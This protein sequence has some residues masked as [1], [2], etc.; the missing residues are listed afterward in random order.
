VLIT[1]AGSAY[2]NGATLIHRSLFISFNSPI[3]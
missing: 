3:V 1:P 2:V